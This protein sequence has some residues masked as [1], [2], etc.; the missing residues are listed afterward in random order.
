M[1]HILCVHLPQWPIDRL[2]RRV[3]MRESRASVLAGHENAK[4]LCQSRPA[5][6]LAPLTLVHTVASRR[7][8]AHACPIARKA[9]VRPGMPL[10]EARALCPK[11]A[12]HPY[13]PHKDLHALRAL[14][15]HMIRFSPIT[16][17]AED[18]GIFLDVTG[19]QRLYGGWANLFEQIAEDL[20][21]LHF[22]HRLA[23]APTPGA[24][25]AVAAFWRGKGRAV[26]P[27]PPWGAPGRLS[28]PS[29]PT[30]LSQQSQKTTCTPVSPPAQDKCADEGVGTTSGLVVTPEKLRDTLA[31]LPVDALRIEPETTAA[32]H[33]LGLETIG[34]L[35]AIPRNQLPS[36]FGP[37]LLLRID[38]TLGLIPEPI[39]PLRPQ[40]PIDAR[41]EFDGIIDSLEIILRTIETLVDRIC[42]NL[43][44]LGHGVRRLDLRL[45]RL[46]APA[47]TREVLFS[48]P[49]RN[50]KNILRLLTRAIETLGVNTRGSPS[51]ERAG[52]RAL[53]R[54]QS[55]PHPD[56]LPRGEGTSLESA[57][58]SAISLHV[59]LSEPVADE[60]F[61]FDNHAEESGRIH[62]DRLVENLTLRL[63]ESAITHAQL[64]ESHLPERAFVFQP[65]SPS[66]GATLLSG[67]PQSSAAVFRGTTV[68]AVQKHGPPVA[69]SAFASCL[70]PLLLYLRP[71]ELQVLVAPSQDREG[72]PI[73][74]NLAGRVHQ[75]VHAV[76]PERIAGLWWEHHYRTR[77]Y[78]AVE[79]DSARRWW[80]FR[81]RESHRWFLHGEFA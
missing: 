22:H 45:H 67:G 69:H 52:V 28:E 1:K 2:R 54:Q 24:A 34:Q 40:P 26:S 80:L 15:R 3:G 70:R 48:R 20:D 59:L 68:P 74:F 58:F 32:L 21:D 79:D 36:R 75:V 60:Q 14:A 5:R 56:P 18:T 71:I 46:Y 19:C 61:S 55:N 12:D 31:P 53:A 8:I 63:G 65:G 43:A 66:V 6:T 42:P 73:S 23:I 47:V 77:D 9:G 13:E 27:K 10:A 76:G 50:P 49:S 35:L 57:G 41:S 44:R 25:W 17:L 7:I 11:L 51:R 37:Q 62:V 39:V 64:I 81:V 72:R 29:L 16:G 38:Q 33:H 78:F 30:L 4:S